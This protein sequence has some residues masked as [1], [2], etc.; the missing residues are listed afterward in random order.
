MPTDSSYIRLCIESFVDKGR[1][2]EASGID[3]SN[4]KYYSPEGFEESRMYDH[5][6]VTAMQRLPVK[7]P[8]SGGFWHHEMT[9]AIPAEVNYP[10]EIFDRIR[11][12]RT[13]RPRCWP[14]VHSELPIGLTHIPKAPNSVF[15]R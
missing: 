12:N 14:F 6:H 9:F 13:K 2:C 3:E 8:S 4:R 1:L 7:Y 15:P 11:P 5:H 10:G